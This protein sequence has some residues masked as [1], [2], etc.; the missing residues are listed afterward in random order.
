[1]AGGAEVVVEHDGVPMGMSPVDN[2]ISAQ[3]AL[4]NLARLVEN[5]APGGA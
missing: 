1:V 4:S 3:M 5:P 2:V